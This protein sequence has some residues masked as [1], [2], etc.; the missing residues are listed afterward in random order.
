M[1]APGAVP[2]V[3]DGNAGLPGPPKRKRRS[4]DDFRDDIVAGECVVCPRT[5]SGGEKPLDLRRLLSIK[6]A[7]VDFYACCR[8][9]TAF[10]KTANLSGRK[11]QSILGRILQVVAARARLLWRKGD[12]VEL[13]GGTS[14]GRN[15]LPGSGAVLSITCDTDLGASYRVRT[16]D[17]TYDVMS[18]GI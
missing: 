13:K 4:D 7:P 9:C 3:I 6:D 5:L 2:A 15:V 12:I 18:A 8:Q 11:Q 16:L 1:A 17:G 14:P 10:L